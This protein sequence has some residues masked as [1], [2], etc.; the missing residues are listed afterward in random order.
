[1]TQMQSRILTLKKESNAVILAH[2]YQTMDIQE[3]ADHVGDSFELA[4]RAQSA[5]QD[6]IVLCGVKFMAESAKILNPSKTVLLPA[7]QAGCPM[8]DM[9]APED[10]KALRAKHPDAAVVCYINSS[11]AVKAE[12]DICCTSSSAERVV[13]SLPQKKVIF[14]PDKN[15]GAYTA[16]L[17][18]EK[19]FILFDGYCPIH[20]FVKPEQLQQARKAYPD[21]EVL[22]HPECGGEVVALADY[23][24][25]TSGI[26]QYVE[27]SNKKSFIIG[28]EVG[29]VERIRALHPDKRAYLLSPG[30]VCANMKK[31]ALDDVLYA[32]EHGVNEITLPADEM[33]AA[34]TCLERMV[35]VK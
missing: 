4:K 30:L 2:Y 21:A 5:R 24:G 10:V 18:P 1:M 14:V 15:L 25:S 31:T 9:I 3:I 11:A 17:V 19:E 28:T 20:H 6:V 8:A 35:A 34:R 29:V 13:R 33:E 23:V 12:C 16:S 32:L 22:V 26:L 27:N 7:A